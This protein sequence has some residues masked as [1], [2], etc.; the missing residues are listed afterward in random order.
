MLWRK[1]DNFWY[2]HKYKVLI[3]IFAIIAIIIAGS[4]NSG[5]E[6]DLEIA[7]VLGNNEI[8]LQNVDEKRALLESLIPGKDKEKGII[9]FVPLTPSRL[10]VEIVIGISQ[11]L[12]LD[13]ETLLPL[14][15]YS[16]FEPLDNYVEKYNLDLND[17]PE[18]KANSDETENTKVYVLPVKELN[19]LAE[20]GFPEDYYFT[21]RLPKENDSDEVMKNKN[22]HIILDYI[23]KNRK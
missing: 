19:F 12:I 6:V 11:V 22:A 1:I 17:F 13:K 15:D 9:S 5:G 16:V 3:A 14:L 2:Y 4:N 8:V 10:E 7:Y 20:M 23:L 18:V 21:I